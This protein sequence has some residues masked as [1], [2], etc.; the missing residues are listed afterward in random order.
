MNWL[1]DQI[2]L[3]VGAALLLVCLWFLIALFFVLFG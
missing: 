3:Y 2:I 1:K